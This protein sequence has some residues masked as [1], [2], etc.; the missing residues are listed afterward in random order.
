STLRKIAREEAAIIKKNSFVV[1]AATQPEVLAVLKEQCR[2]KHARLVRADKSIKIPAG[3]SIGLKG[4]H[5]RINAA[6]TV[7]VIKELQQQG[8]K[9]SEQAI[10]QGLAKAFWPGRLELFK[11]FTTNHELR[12]VLLD[13]AHNPAGMRS[14]AENLQ[15]LRS[16]G[17]KIVSIF[18]VLK[19]KD[20]RRMVEIIAPLVERSILVRPGS[21]RALDPQRIRELWPANKQ[22]SVAGSIPQAIRQAL[23]LAGKKDLV[24]ISGSLYTVGEARKYLIKLNNGGEQNG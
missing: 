16:G 10:K 18:G 15:A 24:T 1:T 9:I 5:Q 6:C 3:W 19:D 11:V 13:G 23:K 8:V 7:A 12:T 21:D 22:V 20:Y 2:K 4:L 14:L 17:T